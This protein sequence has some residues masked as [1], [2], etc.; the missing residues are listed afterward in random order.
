MPVTRCSQ[1]HRGLSGYID[2][3]KELSELSPHEI[4][5]EILKYEAK[6]TRIRAYMAGLETTETS[7]L[8]GG[9]SLPRLHT[10]VARVP[11]P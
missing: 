4:R 6:E 9:D 1:C 2:G 8:S 11:K 10:R 3:E 7:K 5:T